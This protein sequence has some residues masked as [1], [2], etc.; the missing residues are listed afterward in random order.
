MP[1]SQATRPLQRCDML[2]AITP[3]D[4]RHR[5]VRE[6]DMSLIGGAQFKPKC[7]PSQV[8]SRCQHP[9]GES[10]T[11][12]EALDASYLHAHR[13]DLA[14]SALE[15]DLPDDH[16]RLQGLSPPLLY[17]HLTVVV[18]VLWLCRKDHSENISE[19]AG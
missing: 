11:A 4:Q 2:T 6:S 16:C 15:N 9:K 17:K 14:I 10:G 3:N 8:S 19:L 5:A 18:R 12:G 13:S 1:E 7:C